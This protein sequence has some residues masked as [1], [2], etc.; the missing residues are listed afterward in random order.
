MEETIITVPDALAQIVAGNALSRAEMASVMRQVMTGQATPAQI[1]GLLVGL[2]M[3]GETLEEIIGAVEVMRQLSLKVDYQHPYLVDTCGTGGDG[4]CLFNVSTASSLVVAASGGKVAKHGNRSITSRTGSADVLEAAGVVLDLPPEAIARCIDAIG[5][6]FM[7]AQQHHSAMRYAIGP[8]RELRLRTLFN[9]IGPLCNP[10]AAKRQVIGVF[11][12]YLCRPL[13]EV[14]AT[15]GS[16]RVLVVHAAD[17]LDE[18][19]LAAP[20]QVAEWSDGRLREY[21][22]M[23]EDF[24]MAR[25][26]LDGLQVDSAEDSLEL[27]KAALGGRSTGVAAKA[28]R[29]VAINAGA[30]V[31]VSGLEPTLADG[32]ARAEDTIASGLAAEKLQELIEF[33]HSVSALLQEPAG[34]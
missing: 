5:L 9:L 27:I 29:M 11:A 18:F 6:G 24:G 10:A 19:S 1:G 20:T 25:E 34:E 7:F 13:A 8:R 15:L 31:Y 26:S 4:A 22:V 30:A 16:E 33:T 21:T 17:G 14:L 32:V 23:P 3:K 2:R 12:R 28:A